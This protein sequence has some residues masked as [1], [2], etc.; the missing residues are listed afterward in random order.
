M[1]RCDEGGKEGREMK[2]D[3]VGRNGWKGRT[4]TCDRKGMIVERCG[5][6]LRL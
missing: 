2:T 4:D 1:D 5:G 6:K 3:E